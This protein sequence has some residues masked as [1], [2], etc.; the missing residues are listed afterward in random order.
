M[1]RTQHIV[2]LI[3]KTFNCTRGGPQTTL[4]TRRVPESLVPKI[5]LSGSPSKAP[6]AQDRSQSSPGSPHSLRSREG[7]A[8]YLELTFP[9]GN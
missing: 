8:L 4:L 9:A 6:K 7:Y 3:L 2:L 1:K 5:P